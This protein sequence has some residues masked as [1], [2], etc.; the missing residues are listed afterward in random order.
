M[1]PLPLVAAMVESVS[2]GFGPGAVKLMIHGFYVGIVWYGFL[3][4]FLPMQGLNLR[5][6]VQLY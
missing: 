2:G 1:G 3:G 6:W 5:W 4:V